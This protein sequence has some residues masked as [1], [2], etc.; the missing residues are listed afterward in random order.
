MSTMGQHGF[1]QQVFSANIPSNKNQGAFSNPLEEMQRMNAKSFLP[2]FG[3][4][5]QSKANKD[6]SMDTETPDLSDIKKFEFMYKQQ[7]GTI[8]ELSGKIFS[9]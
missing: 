6:N 2:S 1:N 9:P 7:P 3:N 4:D 5:P 8:F